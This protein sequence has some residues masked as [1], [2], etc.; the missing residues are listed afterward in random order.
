MTD[1]ANQTQNKHTFFVDTPEDAKHFDVVKHLKTHPSLL[2]RK[3]NRIQLKDM[4]KISLDLD[5]AVS[6]LQ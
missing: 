6:S 5:D 4:S 3:S 1:V 2:Y